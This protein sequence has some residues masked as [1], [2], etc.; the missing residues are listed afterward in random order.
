MK[1]DFKLY[2]HLIYPLLYPHYFQQA[3]YIIIDYFS[4]FL[5]FFNKLITNS[6]PAHWEQCVQSKRQIKWKFN[7]KSHFVDFV[8]TLCPLGKVIGKFK[9][10]SPLAWWVTI[11]QI[12]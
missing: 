2:F 11:G 3:F 9:I 7:L 12:W 10:Y 4:I 6:F 5:G 1:Y 8:S